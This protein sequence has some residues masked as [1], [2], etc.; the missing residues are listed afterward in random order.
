MKKVTKVKKAAKVAKAKKVAKVSKSKTTKSKTQKKVSG[1][2]A[3]RLTAAQKA[4]WHLKLYVAGK[5]GRSE[6]ALQNLELI[7]EEHLKGKYDLEIIDLLEKPQLA[8]G[9]QIF[10][11]P[12]LIKKVPK[13]VR[14]IIGDLSDTE[15]VLVGLNLKPIRNL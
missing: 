2:K 12:T 1:G 7:C 6:T 11:I 4:Q 8:K 15:R 3:P 13:P 10:A 14:K 5:T 9:D